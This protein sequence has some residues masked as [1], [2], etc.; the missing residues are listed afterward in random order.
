MVYKGSN[1]TYDCRKSKTCFFSNEIRNNFINMSMA[2]YEQNHLLR[3]IKEFQSKTRPQNSESKKVKEDILNSAMALLKGREMVFKAFE[4]EIFLK[5]KELKQSEQS[6][7]SSDGDISLFKL[8]EGTELKILTPKQMFR[9]L[10]IS[11][12]QVKAG[13]KLESLLNEIRKIVYSLYQSK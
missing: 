13:N 3:Y 9:R 8:K 10:P 7:Q 4:S 11:L 6:E 12:A 1:E 2:N 5:P